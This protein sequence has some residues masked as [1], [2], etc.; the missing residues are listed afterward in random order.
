MKNGW[1]AKYI[2]HNIMM[3][4]KDGGIVEWLTRGASNLRIASCM[5][6]KFKPSHGHGVVSLSEKL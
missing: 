5:D 2:H 6:S 1:G 4:N 3:I